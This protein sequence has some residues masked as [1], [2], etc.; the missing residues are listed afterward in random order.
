MPLVYLGSSRRSH[1][2]VVR[3][4]E[5]TSFNT[6]VFW[7]AIKAKSTSGQRMEGLQT[8]FNR[9]PSSTTAC[10]MLNF[11]NHQQLASSLTALLLH[12]HKLSPGEAFSGAPAAASRSGSPY[13]VGQDANNATGV[14]LEAGA[15]HL[16][17]AA[18]PLQLTTTVVVWTVSAATTVH[19]RRML[20]WQ[21][22]P[23][24]PVFSCQPPNQDH[25]WY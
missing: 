20:Q 10:N 22:H 6:G 12:K 24:Q 13:M 17:A 25:P 18:K 8:S 4:H 7:K 9:F 3:L 15:M 11:G 23:M 21:P 19:T 14:L 1:P 2:T 5:A 16:P